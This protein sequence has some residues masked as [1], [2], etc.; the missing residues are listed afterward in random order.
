[1]SDSPAMRHWCQPLNQ[2]V[3]KA[4]P[5][6]VLFVICANDCPIRKPGVMGRTVANDAF[7]KSWSSIENG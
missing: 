5:L 6:L 1:M 2:A 4:L 7:A 3:P